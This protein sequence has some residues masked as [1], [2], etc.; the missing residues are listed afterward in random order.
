MGHKLTKG[1]EGYYQEKLGFSSDC[2]VCKA[3]AK[4]LSFSRKTEDVKHPS[5]ADL[6]TFT[7]GEWVC[8]FECFKKTD[9]Y[10]GPNPPLNTKV[11]AQHFLVPGGIAP[12]GKSYPHICK[13]REC[14]ALQ[15]DPF[16]YVT[17][18]K[19]DAIVGY[20]ASLGKEEQFYCPGPECVKWMNDHWNDGGTITPLTSADVDEAVNSRDGHHIYC[21]CGTALSHGAL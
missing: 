8:G 13:H 10:V 20:L 17:H 14:V 6:S 15:A 12:N 1:P 7:M 9:G 2:S 3:P 16:A 19:A 4:M 11:T 18:P 21:E 5:G